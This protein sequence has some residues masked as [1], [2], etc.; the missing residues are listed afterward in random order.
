MKK[1]KII[2]FWLCGFS[3]LFALSCRKIDQSLLS[4]SKVELSVERAIH[5][6]EQQSYENKPQLHKTKRTEAFLKTLNPDWGKAKFESDESYEIIEAPIKNSDAFTF[7][8]K[9]SEVSPG[10]TRTKLKLLIVKSKK[11][12]T[13][14]ATIMHI[15]AANGKTENINYVSRTNLTGVILFTDLVGNLVNGWR[16]NNGKVTHAISKKEESAQTTALTMRVNSTNDKNYKTLA[17][18]AYCDEY[19]VNWYVRTCYYYTDGSSS[20]GPW[21]FTHSTTSNDCE[22]SGNGGYQLQ[23][24]DCAGVING[25]ARMDSCGCVGG[26]T[27]RLQCPPPCKTFEII[28]A[29]ILDFEGGYVNNSFDSG[30]PT[31]R[32]IAWIT[33]QSFSQSVL[34]VAPTLQNLQNITADDAKEIYKQ[35]FWNKNRLDEVQDGD[36]RYFIFDFYVNSYSIAIKNLQKTLNSLGHNLTVDGGMGDATIAAINSTDVITLYNSY[37]TSR[38]NHFRNLAV[39][40]PKDLKHLAGWIANRIDPFK[41]KT[42]LF[43]KDVNCL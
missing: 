39:K 3:V 29:K 28:V 30:G 43:F 35:K 18:P 36:L 1:T 13:L 16:Y 20:C 25:T 33:W 38:E 26:T 9:N 23:Q 19:T 4:D 21:T 41:L 14:N 6:F 37:R 8:N 11:S 42:E 22:G 24:K 2:V 34:G 12:G 17:E 27:G 5:F 31:N 15:Y 40:R 7:S 10:K 32:G